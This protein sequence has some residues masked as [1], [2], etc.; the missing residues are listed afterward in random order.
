[1]KRLPLF[2]RLFLFFLLVSSALFA[3]TVRVSFYEYPGCH[4]QAKDGT[5]SGYGYDFM[6]LLA[7]EAGWDV[8]Y[9]A[10][11]HPWGEMLEMMERGEIDI[12]DFVGWEPERGERMLFSARPMAYSGCSIR[13]LPEKEFQF[14]IDQMEKWG[15]V[16]VGVLE[17][18]QNEVE[19]KNF[20]E[21]HSI[22]YEITRYPTEEKGVEAL[23]R[24]ELDM[25][26]YDGF[27]VTK[28]LKTIETYNPCR[29]HLVT[30]KDD[31][32]L[33]AEIDEAMT[34][35]DREYP[36]W[37]A[38]L[39]SRYYPVNT[40]V[41]YIQKGDDRYAS[42]DGY[43]HELLGRLNKILGAK[44]QIQYCQRNFADADF[45]VPSFACGVYFSSENTKRFVM[46]NHSAGRLGVDLLTL[47]GASITKE[48]LAH[49]ED[50]LK[51]GFVQGEDEIFRRVLDDYARDKSIAFSLC[52]ARDNNDLKQG[53]VDGR[54]DLV[55]GP[56][57]TGGEGKVV[58]CCGHVD[59]FLA[60]PLEQK[61]LAHSISEALQ[62][63]R[64]DEPE[65]IYELE[66]KYFSDEN[67]TTRL[68]RLG[69]YVE[70]GLSIRQEDGR[71]SGLV[72]EL[73]EL[74]AKRQGW[75]LK[76]IVASYSEVQRAL[77]MGAIDIMGAA[78]W[79]PERAKVYDYSKFN[80]GPLYYALMTRQDSTLLENRPDTWQ[81]KRV[82]ILRGSLAIQNL[83]KFLGERGVECELIPFNN[84]HE[85]ENQVREG[86][87]DAVYTLANR[88]NS[89][90]LPLTVLP[91]QLCYFCF[92]KNKPWVK[93]E[94][95]SALEEL[96]RE[97]HKCIL[98]LYEK[99]LF[100]TS[101]VLSLDVD[102]IE[103]V[104]S[105][106]GK[107]TVVSFDNILPP[108][109]TIDWET[110]V[111][112]G[113]FPRI[114]KRFTERTGLEFDCRVNDPAAEVV[115]SINGEE[116]AN[117]KTYFK[118]DWVDSPFCWV[119]QKNPPVDTR[120]IVALPSFRVDEIELVK[121]FGY[122]TLLLDGFS[123]C[124]QAVNDGRAGMT[125][126]RMAVARYLIDEINSFPSLQYQQ[127]DKSTFSR[128][129]SMFIS[130][131]S[132]PK[133]RSLLT[134]S[135]SAL[136]EDELS[137][138]L[139]ESVYE[140]RS[141]TVNV[142][143]FLWIIGIIVGIAL[144]MSVFSVYRTNL[145][146]AASR[147]K[148]TFLFNMSHDIRTPM[149]AILG[150]TE[151]ALR[152]GDDPQR[153]ADSLQ[154][155]KT[156]GGHL[157]NLINDILEMSR[158]EEGKMVLTN[159]PLD[160]REMIESVKLMGEVLAL[161]KAIDFKV[162]VR[163]LPNPYVYTDELHFNEVLINVLSNAVKYTPEG[164]CVQYSIEQVS[165][166]MDGQAN[167]RFEI[168]DTGIGM[169][170]EFQEHLFE[171]FSR[172]NTS[173][174]SRQEGAGLGLSIVK[175]ITDLAGG[176]LRVES[177]L[178]K[179]TKFIIVMPFQVMDE[180]AIAS[181]EEEHLSV[182]EWG[183]DMALTGKRVLVVEDNE[184]NREIA[185]EILE[186]S[187]LVVETAEDGKIAVQLVSSKGPDYY[188]FVLMDIQM[189]VM[190]GY[191]ATIAIRKMPGYEQLPIIALSANAFEE[192]RKK[193][194]AVGM[195]AHEPK[196]MKIESLLQT[197]RRVM[198]T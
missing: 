60:P 30:R 24:G 63:M 91:T 101:G 122:K 76:P 23:R 20:A 198:R 192:D 16:R 106:R 146:R 193:S 152:H 94:F 59:F 164:G 75:N 95:D 69:A 127:I 158:I 132:S 53:L 110:G 142:K 57:R 129:I 189:P 18:D 166:V 168:S 160:L 47:K 55:I 150:Y 124:Y 43:F 96:L 45:S 151:I 2:L 100:S 105:R 123:E 185:L 28:G 176:S 4:L 156:S 73:T 165:D 190:N 40:V 147:A 61:A 108:F 56:A 139:F 83:K 21:D 38:N 162:N 174:V 98:E 34:R 86:H 128:V 134:K 71:F 68:V 77:A 181:F 58:D 126:D 195:N 153:V 154:K 191:E 113:F 118:Q 19:F 80:I 48:S 44:I 175:R 102:E 50:E 32:A 70:Q 119:K 179:G 81:K 85:A 31:V 112:G 74:V 49:R 9:V 120:N 5:K 6:E 115:V 33:M 109:V 107:K 82:G 29:N 25:V 187:G 89:D 42:M 79:T 130:T 37:M 36:D 72:S 117:E 125:I 131:S 177:E 144:L 26:A 13:I 172:E 137:T 135:S 22:D 167:Y 14:R 97:N 155:I 169:S 41:A 35:L 145:A 62:Y 171:A 182:E 149:N 196:P 78:V 54:F 3:R 39:R 111:A 178:G 157:L 121:K 27:A 64:M 90:L 141:G 12:V 66:K 183:G 46:P 51:I 1:M 17:G 148:T 186:D 10:F 11:D 173:T 180:A 92:N 15:R 116:P 52:A 140:K 170:E 103:Y 87:L 104:A 84:L 197:M 7:L 93:E 194:L 133:L 159:A 65:F 88:D 163:K 67:D 138:M 99:H 8:E 136:S 161:P 184:M 188:D 114:F 143:T